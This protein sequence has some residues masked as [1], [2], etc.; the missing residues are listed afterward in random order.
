MSSPNHDRRTG[1]LPRTHGQFVPRWVER[2]SGGGRDAIGEGGAAVAGVVDQ[3]GELP[4]GVGLRLEIARQIVRLR[5]HRRSCVGAAEVAAQG[6]VG[7]V[8][9]DGV[10]VANGEAAPPR[11]VREGSDGI[12]RVERLD[13]AARANLFRLPPPR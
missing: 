7:A 5:G 10:G 9:A 6:V 8:L 13:R 2:P 12:R 1:Q 3:R 4:L 11:V